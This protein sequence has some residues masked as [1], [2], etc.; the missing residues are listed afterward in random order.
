MRVEEEEEDE[1]VARD[2]MALMTLTWDL[3]QAKAT[4]QNSSR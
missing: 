4:L 2:H 3:P 1:E